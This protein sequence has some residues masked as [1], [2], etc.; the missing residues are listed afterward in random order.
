M[1]SIKK[2]MQSKLPAE[3]KWLNATFLLSLKNGVAAGDFIQN[4]NSYK[5]SAEFKKKATAA[6]K[7]KK[8]VKKAAPKKKVRFTLGGLTAWL[9]NRTQL[10]LSF[11]RPRSRSRL[12]PRRLLPRRPPPR[13]LLLKRLPRRR[14]QRRRLPRRYVSRRILYPILYLLS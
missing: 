7:P 14:R 8:V 11:N 10:N 6:A 3:K 2:L 4:K 9:P 12:P 5:L 1:I 13:R